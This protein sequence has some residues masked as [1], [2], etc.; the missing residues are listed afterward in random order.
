VPSSDRRLSALIEAGIAMV[1]ELDIDALLQ[2]IAD[3]AREVI[4][5]RYGAV[6]VI[7]EPVELV[8]LVQSGMDESTVRMIGH[9]P[10]GEG[11][12]GAV[13][14][15]DKP[16]RL[17]EISDHP[18]SVGFPP[19][20][21]VMHTFLGIPIV[22]RKKIWGR[23]YLSEKVDGSYF[24]EDDERTGLLFAAQA[25][26][27]LEN[28]HLSYRMRDMAILEERDRIS[29]ELH[30]GV[31]QAVYSVGLSIQS[32][33]PL[34]ES[35]PEKARQRLDEAINEL[36]NVVRDVRS[37]I[38]ELQPKSVEQRGLA[39][40]IRELVRDLEVNTL[41]ETTVELDEELGELLPSEQRI[42]MIQ[43]IREV[44]SNIARHAEA[45]VVAVSCGE[46]GGQLVLT[47]EDDGVGFDPSAVRRGHGLRNIEYRAAKLGGR[48]E[49]EPRHPKGSILTLEM[50]S[51]RKA[52]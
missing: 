14:E 15:Q 46:Q 4:G 51:P 6:G 26:V 42:H 38:F 30:D 17:K 35:D 25:G 23:L 52:Q 32:S 41:A 34:F 50:P 22:V 12:L 40:A 45:H 9:L 29:K 21:P 48:I 1:S 18:R 28:A 10:T 2:K 49:I 13:I 3:L 24:S 39:P 33:I 27:A 43:L 8:Q 47:V 11:V 20:H 16:L 5:A 19:H 37:Y 31:I 7:G 44:L 36:D